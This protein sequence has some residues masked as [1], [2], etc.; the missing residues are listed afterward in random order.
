MTSWMS[1]IEEKINQ[2]II[3]PN[4]KKYSRVQ[5]PKKKFFLYLTDIANMTSLQEAKRRRWFSSWSK[6]CHVSDNCPRLLY[7]LKLVEKIAAQSAHDV[8]MTLYKRWNDVTC[9]CWNDV[10]TLKR[11]LYNVILTSCNGWEWIDI[12]NL[13]GTWKGSFIS[14][15]R[16]YKYKRINKT[17][18]RVKWRKKG[19]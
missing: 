17:F 15:I 18:V 6:W 19:W 16:I 3:S 11:R 9:G 8:R 12:K 14:R 7:T 1:W 5:S 10:K 4:I 2:N 13:E